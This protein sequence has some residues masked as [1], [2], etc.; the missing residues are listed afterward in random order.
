[1][2]KGLLVFEHEKGCTTQLM[3]KDGEGLGFTVLTGKS[4]EKLFGRLV[5]LE[6][7]DRSLGVR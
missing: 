7:K 4:L 6:E 3:S 1:L 2:V 5:A